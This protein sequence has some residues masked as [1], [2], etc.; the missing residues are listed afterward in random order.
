MTIDIALV[1]II[2]GGSL[3]LFVTEKVRMD[4]TALIVMGALVVTGLV[5][6]EDAVA[7]FANGAVIAVWA[8]FILSDGL[9]RTGIAKSSRPGELP[10]E[11]LAEPCVNLSTHTA[12]PIQ[13]CLEAIASARTGV[14]ASAYSGQPNVQPGAGADAIS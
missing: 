1:L 4:V 9:T 5:S 7:G 10:P 3:V 14:D 12:P 11:A 2:L 13:P 6:P 8:M